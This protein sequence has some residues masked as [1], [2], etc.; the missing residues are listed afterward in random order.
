MG[1]GTRFW[2][3]LSSR[4]ITTSCQ[5][6]SRKR[7]R[8]FASLPWTVM[9]M[10]LR[11]C[12]SRK[13]LFRFRTQ[14]R[15]IARYR[16]GDVHRVSE[17]AEAT[18]HKLWGATR[19]K[20]R[21][22]AVAP[23]ADTCRVGGASYGHGRV[24]VAQVPHCSMEGELPRTTSISKARGA[25]R[26]SGRRLMSGICWWISSNAGYVRNVA[27]ISERLSRCCAKGTVGTKS[28]RGFMTR[29]PKR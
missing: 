26:R 22:P 18:V 17:L 28:P 14:L 3:L 15:G 4:S 13:A 6:T 2:A 20:C 16:L 29:T 12:G 1:E 23:R 27:R 10:R 24:P 5:T 8:Q 25:V 7:S 19:R 21:L 11:A 9:E